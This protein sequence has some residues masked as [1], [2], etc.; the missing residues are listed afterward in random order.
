[1]H[2]YR[3]SQHQVDKN[4]SMLEMKYLN[5]VNTYL[6]RYAILQIRQTFNLIIYAFR[7]DQIDFYVD[8]I[9]EK[10]RSIFI[11]VMIRYPLQCSLS[12]FY[13]GSV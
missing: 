11:S 13:L 3:M 10:S 2:I 6:L 1:M 4:V 12:R 5:L 9:M 8:M 7:I